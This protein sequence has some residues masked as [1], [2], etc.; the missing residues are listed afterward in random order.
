MLPTPIPP[1]AS[2]IVVVHGEFQARTCHTCGHCWRPRS[3]VTTLGGFLSFLNCCRHQWSATGWKRGNG[4][5]HSC[6]KSPFSPYG[7]P[8]P[9]LT[10]LDLREKTHGTACPPLVAC[11]ATAA[12]RTAR[13]AWSLPHSL[14][15]LPS[16]LLRILPT[17]WNLP[18]LHRFIEIHI[19][20]GFLF[21]CSCVGNKTI[22]FL[23][24]WKGAVISVKPPSNNI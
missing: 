8:A 12:I 10:R 9:G 17:L 2:G 5:S 22:R 11:R 19:G 6:F 24:L 1:E 3:W 16:Q 18:F 13:E 14:L 15:T 20:S 7:F 21:L 4:P 23:N